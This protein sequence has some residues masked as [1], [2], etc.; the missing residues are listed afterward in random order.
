MNQQ[1]FII[2]EYNK[3][4]IQGVLD[5]WE[6][7]SGWGRPNTEEYEKWM[8]TPFGECTVIVGEDQKESI[9]CQLIFTPTELVINGK[10]QKAL[11]ASA[12]IIHGDYRGIST[13]DP[14]SIII[15]LIQKAY[16]IIQTKNYEWLYSFPALGMAKIFDLA[17]R[18]GLSPW[19]QNFYG[20]FEIIDS[21]EKISDFSV[22]ILDK[23]PNEIKSIWKQF[24]EL[25]KDKSFVTRNLEW[26]KYKWDDDIK[27]G[28]YDT[29]GKLDGYA[30]IKQE[31]G[32]ILD[33]VMISS[34][35]TSNILPQL[36]R[37]FDNHLKS[38]R[39]SNPGLKF[40]KT[41][42]LSEIFCDVRIQPVDFQF[43]FGLSALKDFK[44]LEKIDLN[45]WYVFP[46]D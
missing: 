26:L 4:D 40:M 43:V 37:L 6:Y 34:K 7:H 5:L 12:P 11:K 19:K 22:R 14:N 20:C 16:Q 9:I 3:S 18:I 42:L 46:N 35:E 25:N 32:L 2:R 8:K 15:Q 45:D 36:K 27:V 13:K 29:K 44:K 24:K 33:F 31:S 41:S 23:F 10:I 38:T 1:K 28:I 30:V 39:I 17:H 21:N